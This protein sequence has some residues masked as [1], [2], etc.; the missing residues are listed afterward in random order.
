[1]AIPWLIGA[2]VVGLG[3]A[4][5]DSYEEDERRDRARRR[6]REEQ[7]EREVQAR[8]Q[9][10]TAK[11]QEKQR[12]EQEQ[13]RRLKAFAESKA[14]VILDKYKITSLTP[15]NLAANAISNPSHAIADVAKHYIESDTYK[16]LDKKVA[17]IEKE[18]EERAELKKIL[19]GL[20]D[21]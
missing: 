16:D 1:M 19:K 3:K 6:E 2:A 13:K 17:A 5:Y 7:R 8:K 4:V 20:K 18:L 10:E 9:R 11:K 15:A 12:D 21:G 14:I